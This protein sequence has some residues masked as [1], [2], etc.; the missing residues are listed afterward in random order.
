MHVPFKQGAWCALVLALSACG[1]T[2]Q[3]EP[4]LAAAGGA[5]AGAAATSA[6]SGS[7]GAGSGGHGGTVQASAGQAGARAVGATGG[8]GDPGGTSGA[9]DAG[10]GG[11]SPGDC[12][13]ATLDGLEVY[14]AGNWDP[15]GYPPYALDRCTLVYVSGADGADK[16]ALLLRD[17]VTGSE[18]VLETADANPR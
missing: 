12:S 16:G 18:L 3:G 13:L 14:S 4:P 17:L 9:G 5:A 2:H 11:D 10:V 7:A 15:L 6:G 8:A 1:V